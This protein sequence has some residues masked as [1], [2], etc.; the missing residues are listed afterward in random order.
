[1]ANNFHTMMRAHAHVAAAQYYHSLK[2]KN[3]GWDKVRK[4]LE[5]E[6]RNA[7]KADCARIALEAMRGVIA[8]RQINHTLRRRNGRTTTTA[9]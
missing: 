2:N 9:N 7:S 4:W 8:A 1:M 5:R 3:K 6:F